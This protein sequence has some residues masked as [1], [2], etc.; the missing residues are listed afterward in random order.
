MVVK[1][2]LLFKMVFSLFL[3]FLWAENG[4]MEQETVTVS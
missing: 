2:K 1:K 4:V 3:L